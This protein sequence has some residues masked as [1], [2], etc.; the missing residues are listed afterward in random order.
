MSDTQDKNKQQPG[1]SMRQP[2]QPQSSQQGQQ[3]TG[4]QTG[5]PGQQPEQQKT[6]QDDSSKK[7][8]TQGGQDAEKDQPGQR[9]AS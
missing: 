4:N 1:Q 2:G 3:Q 7:N 9:R 6:P 5:K 8:P